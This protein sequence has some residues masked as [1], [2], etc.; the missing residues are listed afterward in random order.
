MLLVHEHSAWIET[1]GLRG[2]KEERTH[3]QLRQCW[4]TVA[5]GKAN[6]EGSGHDFPNPE[7]ANG[8]RSNTDSF[9]LSRQI[10]AVNRCEITKRS[11]TSS[12]KRPRRRD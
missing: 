10:G 1:E 7:P 3:R 8:T 11:S 4:P 9:P 12:P 5:S 2:H 6:E